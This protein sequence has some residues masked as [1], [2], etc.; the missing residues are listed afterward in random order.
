[1][2]VETVALAFA[3]TIDAYA[4]QKTFINSV[5]GICVAAS[6]HHRRLSITQLKNRLFS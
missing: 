5:P 1:V 4:S 6:Y 3:V 2:L